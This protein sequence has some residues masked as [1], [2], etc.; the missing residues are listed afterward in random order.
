[1]HLLRFPLLAAL[2]VALAA[3]A[4]AQPPKKKKQPPAPKVGPPRAGTW[5]VDDEAVFD[6]LMDRLTELAKAGKPLAHDKLTARMKPGKVAVT[7]A[8]P[9]DKPLAP[10]EVYKAALPGVFV[11]GS[12]YKDA[13]TG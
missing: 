8:R 11:L 7:P 4:D 6:N 12:V 3:G 5:Y 10:E 13:K 1:M 2:L 9:G